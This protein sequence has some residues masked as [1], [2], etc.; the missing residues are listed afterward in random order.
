MKC[1]FERTGFMSA[2]ALRLC[3]KNSLIPII[4]LLTLLTPQG[5]TQT[6]FRKMSTGKMSMGIGAQRYI[7]PKRSTTLFRFHAQ[8]LLG[9]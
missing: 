1:T 4:C 9:V 3:M 5:F 6:S 7:P 8:T 2:D